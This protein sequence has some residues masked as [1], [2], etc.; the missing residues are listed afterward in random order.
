MRNCAWQAVGGET[1]DL[2]GEED[3]GKEEGS[4]DG[5]WEI[6]ENKVLWGIGKKKETGIIWGT[7]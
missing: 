3:G 6:E 2:G 7:L 5:D 1:G 4:D